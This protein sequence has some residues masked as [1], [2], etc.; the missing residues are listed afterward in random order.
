MA[1]LGK[2]LARLTAPLATTALAVLLPVAAW[3]SSDSILTDIAQRRRGGILG[4]IGLLCCLGVVL[5][6]VA[7]LVLLMMRRSRP[8]RP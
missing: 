3:A 2:W 5:V 1:A 6:V 8:P 4:G 7:V